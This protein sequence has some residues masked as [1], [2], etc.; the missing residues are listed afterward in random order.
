MVPEH[1]AGIMLGIIGGLTAMCWGFFSYGYTEAVRPHGEIEGL[2]E[3]GRQYRG[4]WPR[5][6]FCHPPGLANC[7][8]VRADGQ[9][10]GRIMGRRGCCCCCRQRR[11]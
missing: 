9:G 5:P 11:E 10:A 6:S 1:L 7:R 3:H 4:A 2:F 8:D